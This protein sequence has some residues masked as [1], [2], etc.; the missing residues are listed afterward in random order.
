MRT[1]SEAGSIDFRCEFHINL[2][3]L[4]E[5]M[6][7]EQMTAFMTGFAKVLAAAAPGPEPAAGLAGEG[8]L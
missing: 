8:G 6:S 5:T 3:A 2:G 4:S 1:F 7:E